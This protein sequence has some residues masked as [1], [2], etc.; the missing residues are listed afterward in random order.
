[1]NARQNRKERAY[2]YYVHHQL[3]MGPIAQKLEITLDTLSRYINEDAKAGRN[4]HLNRTKLVLNDDF[5]RAE[6]RDWLVL[7]ISE[8]KRVIEEVKED[9]S[10]NA[11]ERSQHI[12]AMMTAIEKAATTAKRLDPVLH[13]ER[14]IAGC[15]KIIGEVLMEESSELL[16]LFLAKTEEIER[17]ILSRKEI[18]GA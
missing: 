12:T 14:V 11:I 2:T 7:V 3:E 17:R 16:E 18:W 6:Y 5:L 8:A 10:C 15:L 9:Q 13:V 1:M 4:W